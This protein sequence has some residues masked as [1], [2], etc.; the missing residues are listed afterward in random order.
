[1]KRELK[2]G[3]GGTEGLER[4]KGEKAIKESRETKYSEVKRKEPCQLLP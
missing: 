1:M 2:L 3:G 4:G